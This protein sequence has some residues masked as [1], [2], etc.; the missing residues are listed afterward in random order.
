MREFVHERRVQLGDVAASGRLRLDALA[1]Y[2]QDVAHDDGA[3]GGARGR[4]VLRRME[5][6]IGRLPS[7]EAPVR[8]VTSCSGAGSR[9][10]ER[11]TIVTGPGAEVDARA[12]WVHL[13]ET[14][15]PAPLDPSFFS[16]WGPDVPRVSARLRLDGPP[17]GVARR[18][19]PLRMTD[20]DVLG[21]VNNAIAL[22]AVED[23]LLR[24]AP[25]R[26]ITAV[27]VEYRDPLDLDAS[28]DL[29]TAPDGPGDLRVW[30][31]VGDKPVVTARIAT[32]Q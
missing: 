32:R 4:W 13:D 6:A 22:A 30:L 27:E 21:H 10:A 31:V 8:L 7:F 24:E 9:W 15:R 11:R 18:P 12:L 26:T 20:V 1:R 16:T 14:G 28:V 25:R 3:D 5:L 2:L 29:A 17:P 19:W 23:A